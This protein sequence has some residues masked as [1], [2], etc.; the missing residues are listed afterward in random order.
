MAKEYVLAID[1]GTTSTRAMLFQNNGTSAGAAQLEHEQIYPQAGWVEHDPKEIWDKTQQVVAKVFQD[2]NLTGDSI[3][4]IGITNQRE[5]TVVWDRNTG[6]PVYNAIV[7]QDTRTQAIVEELGALGGGADRYK[8]KV[9]LPLATYFSG[10]KV[11]WILDNV[12]S[13]RERAEAGDLVFG[14]MDTWVIWNLTGGPDGGV[15]V[16]DVTNASRTLLMDVHR[17]CWD[18]ELLDFFGVPAAM[19][20]EIRPSV[21]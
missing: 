1:Q 9:G 11:R 8:A 14:N 12:D 15:H 7:W 18:P 21:G 13:A 2:N 20:P 10:P 17:C 5:T 16:T 3:A 19:L 4:A 6:E